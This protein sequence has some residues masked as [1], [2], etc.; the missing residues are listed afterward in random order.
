M[1]TRKKK[2]RKVRKL[3][4]S[5]PPRISEGNFE[6]IGRW[7]ERY[8]EIRKG[9]VYT[10]DLFGRNVDPA[11]TKCGEVYFTMCHAYA[12]VPACPGLLKLKQI[13]DQTRLRALS[14]AYRV[15]RRCERHPECNAYITPWARQW[16]CNGGFK[17]SMVDAGHCFRIE[18]RKSK[19]YH[20]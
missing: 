4:R 10:F 19:W 6:E 3:L 1:A 8:G 20:D 16:G 7:M 13:V 18:C 9:Q 11:D 12:P 15:K 14:A 17:R 5:I 2:T